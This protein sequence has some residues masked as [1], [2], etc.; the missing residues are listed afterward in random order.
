M[1]IDEDGRSVLFHGVN[2]VY[3]VAP[4]IPSTEDFDP[5]DSLNDEDIENL[6]QWGFNFVRLGVMWEAVERVQGQYDTEYLQKV[7]QLIDK[8]GNAGIYTL[9][10][11]HQNAF[12]R[13]SCG[14]GF[15]NF[16]AKQAAKKPYCINR[17]VDWFLSPIYSSFG[18]CQDMSSFDYSLDS[19]GNPEIADCITKPPKDY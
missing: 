6:V 5:F 11:M 19:D 13:I 9:V 8:L 12:A 2:V 14:E 17:F 1:F 3:K 10:D 4:Y 16:Y 15:P 18:F 7:A